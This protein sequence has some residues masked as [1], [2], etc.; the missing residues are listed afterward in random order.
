MI[1]ARLY[2]RRAIGRDC[3]DNGDVLRLFTIVALL[4]APL[5]GP[6]GAA[7]PGADGFVRVQLVLTTSAREAV[8]TV[9]SGS[10]VSGLAPEASDVRITVDGNRV[11]VFRDAAG[12]GEA[13][14]TLLL[15]GV[16]RDSVVRWRLSGTPTTAARLEVYN[17]NDRARLRLVD[18]VDTPAADAEFESR[19]RDLIDGG[20]LTIDGGPNPLV[21]AFYYPWFQH[22]TW[23]SDKLQDRPLFLYSAEQPDEVAHSL[24]DARAAGIDAVV[25]SWRGDTDWNDRRLGFILDQAQTIGLR[26]SILTETELA[27]EGPEGTVKPLVADKM[28]AWLEK[29]FDRFGSHPAFLRVAGRPVV[30]VY[31][32]ESFSSADWQDIV[33][34]LQRGGRDLLLMADTADPSLLETFDGAFTYA[35]A[36]IPPSDLRA[37]DREQT[38]R[39]ATYDLLAGGRRRVSAATVSPGYDDTLLDRE[40]TM[41]VDR[42]GGSLYDA[43]WEAA[44]G[45]QPDWVL[46][47][48]WNEFW[49]NTHVEPSVRYGH[50]YQAS[51][52]QW[53][54]RFRSARSEDGKRRQSSR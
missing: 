44:L 19:G 51:T 11:L 35:P 10:L 37:F 5:V 27:T 20:P 26:V 2:T 41:R 29:A 22:P 1:R 34:S 30:F 12:S 13:R 42:A 33:A 18:R 21:M 31:V 48:S 4:G 3:S 38:L 6:V 7:P 47:T 54:G 32:A 46:V 24:R 16:N 15:A 50:A 43:S 52:R 49:E 53:S 8:I 39:T 28:R 14:V 9:E 40:T 36:R 17:A 45:A 23:D 25:V